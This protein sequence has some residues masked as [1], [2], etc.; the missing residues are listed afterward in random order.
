MIGTVVGA[1][2][3][4]TGTLAVLAALP[5][6]TLVATTPVR[7]EPRLLTVVVV[8]LVAVLLRGRGGPSRIPADRRRGEHRPAP[9]EAGMSPRGGGLAVRCKEVVH[10]YRRGD[11]EVVALRSVDLEVA[12]GETLAVYGP[13]GSGKSTLVALLGGLI[14]PTAGQTWIGDQ[15]ISRMPGRAAAAAARRHRRHGAPGR[16]PQPV[17]LRHGRGERRVRAAGG[18]AS[19]GCRIRP[20]CSTGSAWPTSLTAGSRRCPVASSSGWRWRLRSPSGPACCSPTS[21]RP[22]STHR[23]GTRC[24]TCCTGS[25][26]GSAATIVVVTHDPV[27]GQRLGRTITMRFG[28]VG[29]AGMNGR[30]FTLIGRDGGLQLPDEHLEEWPPGTLVDVVRDGAD[31]R[32]R[33]RGTEDADGPAGA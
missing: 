8:V 18:P 29:Q 2:V 25:T 12:A 19:C 23:A 21:R 5:G 17:A 11:T 6:V 22:S 10:I 33:R 27:V 16:R 24:S 3:G 20:T 4:Y 30:Q 9:R 13:S 1:V 14:P 31:L 28:R 15:E 32:I 26:R 7:H